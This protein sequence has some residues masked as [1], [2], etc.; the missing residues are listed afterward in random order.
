MRNGE[1]PRAMRALLADALATIVGAV[2]GNSTVVSYVE[3]CAGIGDGARTGLASVVTG[4]LFIL[5]L[6]FSPLAAMLGQGIQT[7]GGAFV[8]PVIAP[9]LIMVGFM[10]MRGVK[11]IAW[12]EPTEGIPAFLTIM[13]TGFSFSITEGIA[14]GFMSY[15]FLKLLTGRFREIHPF[16]FIVSVIFAVRYF[17]ISL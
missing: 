7:S 12:D 5:A 3:S 13:L 8:Y 14:F 1:L 10:M 17:Y 16:L 2:C 6:F 15:T 9:A 4:I 11:F